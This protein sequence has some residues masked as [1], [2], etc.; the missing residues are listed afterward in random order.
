MSHEASGGAS[1]RLT[2]KRV[3]VVVADVQTLKIDEVVERRHA[4]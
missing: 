1:N 2:E 4:R 3:D